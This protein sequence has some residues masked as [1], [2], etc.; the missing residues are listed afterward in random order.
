[1]VVMVVSGATPE[2]ITNETARMLDVGRTD[3]GKCA[4]RSPTESERLF[5]LQFSIHSALRCHESDTV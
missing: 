5:S 4:R 1:M 3:A 2:D